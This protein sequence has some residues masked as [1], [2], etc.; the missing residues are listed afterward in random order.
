MSVNS[1]INSPGRFA[2]Q[3]FRNLLCHFL[4]I[5]NNIKFNYSYFNE[6]SD[7]GIYLYKDGSKVRVSYLNTSLNS[8]M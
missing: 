6:F 1:T 8:S 5:N 3:F 2:N 4:S 7:L